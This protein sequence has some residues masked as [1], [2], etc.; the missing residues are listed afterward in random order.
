M[1]PDPSQTAEV[2]VRYEIILMRH[3]IA[4]A[5]GAP[6]FPDDAGRPLTPDGRRKMK[7]AGKGLVRLRPEID[8]IVTSPLL[9]AAETAQIV[10]GAMAESPPLDTLEPLGSG[11]PLESLITFLGKHPE[12]QRP[13]IVGHE[14][15]FSDFAARLIGAGRN[16]NLAFKKGGCC[17][18]RF[19]GLPAPAQGKLIWWL[20]PSLLRSLG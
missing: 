13:L 17:L 8:W 4:V 20:T 1:K 2:E 11:G 7:E 14:P 18:I 3:G 6:A 9:R 5:S 12:R 19:S 15:Q 10:A 16:A